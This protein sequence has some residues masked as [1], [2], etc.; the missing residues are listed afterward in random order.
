[1]TNTPKLDRM[2]GVAMLRSP[3]RAT[4]N[5]APRSASQIQAFLSIKNRRAAEPFSDPSAIPSSIAIV[6]RI[7]SQ[8][9][10]VKSAYRARLR[11]RLTHSAIS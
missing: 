8:H 11:L 1:M 6:A 9:S 5:G 4:V 10:G 3:H 7:T 2:N